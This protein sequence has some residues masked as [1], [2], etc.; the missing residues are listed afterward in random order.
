MSPIRRFSHLC[1]PLSFLCSI[2]LHSSRFSICLWVLFI[3]LHT[4]HPTIHLY[5]PSLP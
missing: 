5:I 2:S 4:P 1:S 3:P